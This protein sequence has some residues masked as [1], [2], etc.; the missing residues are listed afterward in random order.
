MDTYMHTYTHS[1]GEIA[2]NLY[3]KLEELPIDDVA[4]SIQENEILSFILFR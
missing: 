4:F 2:F 1:Y 3:I